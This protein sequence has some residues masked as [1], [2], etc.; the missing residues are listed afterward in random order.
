MEIVRV[1]AGKKE[2][3]ASRGEKEKEGEVLKEEKDAVTTATG[4]VWEACDVLVDFSGRGVVGFVVRRVEQWRDLVRDAVDEIVEWDPEE[5]DGG[6]GFF[7][8]GDDGG[9]GIGES[10]GDGD[11]EDDDENENEDQ[12]QKKKADVAF[13]QE[14][15]NSILRILKQIAQIYPAILSNRLKKATE[16]FVTSPAGMKRLEGLIPSLQDI[17]NLIDEVAGALYE[18]NIEVSFRHLAMARVCATKAVLMTVAPFD[19]GGGDGRD[20]SEDKF[21]AWSK[22]WFNVINEVAE[23]LHNSAN[24]KGS[25][26]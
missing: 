19:A 13:L 17:P 23:P 21:A 6:D 10:G 3:A 14:Q 7:D 8:L 11:G 26:K 25:G 20:D 12:S 9:D 15:K 5:D 24:Q 4:R 16:S 1:I 22:I 18:G 2:D